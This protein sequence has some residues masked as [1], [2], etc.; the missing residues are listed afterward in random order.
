[1]TLILQSQVFSNYYIHIMCYSFLS[2]DMGYNH[3]EFLHI[4]HLTC[5]THVNQGGTL[6]AHFVNDTIDNTTFYMA[7]SYFHILCFCYVMKKTLTRI[8]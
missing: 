8:I 5:D 3:Y 6:K 4:T 7:I 2:H 1:M